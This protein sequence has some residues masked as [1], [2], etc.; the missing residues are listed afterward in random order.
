MVRG[1]TMTLETLK[2]YS[3]VSSIMHG[4]NAEFQ[5][6]YMPCTQCSE[7]TECLLSEINHYMNRSN[8]MGA[9]IRHWLN[10]VEDPEI[11][12]IVEV[13]YLIGPDQTG[14]YRKSWTWADTC[15]QVF[16]FSDQRYAR[17][18]FFDWF[19]RNEAACRCI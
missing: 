18:K 5:S 16:G 9:E 7:Q 14:R 13:H 3:Q 15:R 17:R 11:R 12:Q 10:G 6:T 19:K 2:Q 8:S 1:G 4:I